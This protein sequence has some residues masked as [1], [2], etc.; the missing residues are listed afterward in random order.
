[1]EPRLYHCTTEP[2]A[3]KQIL[4]PNPWLSGFSDSLNSLNSLNSMKVLLHLK[5]TPL[6]SILFP[7]AVNRSFE[8]IV[9]VH[10]ILGFSK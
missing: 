4:K 1:M 10:N 8:L 7:F 6:V 5:K 3:T 9:E 2:Q